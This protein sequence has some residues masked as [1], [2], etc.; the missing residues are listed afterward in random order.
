V[1]DIGY[2]RD[3]LREHVR[4]E[5]FRRALERVVRPGDRVLDLGTGL[6]TFAFFAAEA[7]AAHVWAV[8]GNPIIHVARAVGALN[9]YGDR[10]TFVRGWIPSV[11]LPE[12]A[13]LVVCEDFPPRLLDGRTFRLLRWVHEGYAAP[14]ARALPEAAT[15]YTAPVHSR[16]L[17]ERVVGSADGETRYGI[18]WTASR[19]YAAN[20]PAAVAIP[21]DALAT[22]PAALGTV[23]LDRP[24][25]LEALR[26][27][28]RWTAPQPCTVYGLAYWFDLDLGAG[29][30][31][32]NAPGAE[33][34]SWGQL[35]LPLEEPLEV[36]GGGEVTAAVEPHAQPDGCPGWLAWSI[37]AGGV[38]RRGYEL[39]G[40]PA[41][42][43]D[44][45]A[46]SPDFVPSLDDAGRLEANVL[47]LTDGLR[48]VREIAEAVRR[49]R[50][51]LSQPD[52]ER[53]VT[54]VLRGR[55]RM[56]RAVAAGGR[57][58]P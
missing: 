44:F 14:R 56:D 43:A 50:P 15:L 1:S 48:S 3:L 55:I 51:N 40:V 20:A 45:E 10:V 13:D 31:L 27:R 11:R 33:P 17:W 22:A 32:S 6:G 34:G 41:S 26:G 39:A 2:Y 57:E 58:R 35:F 52:A 38:T 29:A 28:A 4:I 53:V 7:G 25:S 46:A 37:A 19:E 18:D 47:D 21:G 24:P 5:A 36:A 16:A 23:Q 42:A 49:A 30:V 12:R 9:G 54:E 8:D